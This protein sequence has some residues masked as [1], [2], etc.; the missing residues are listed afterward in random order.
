MAGFVKG[1]EGTLVLETKELLLAVLELS[2]PLVLS[3]GARGDELAQRAD[4]LERDSRHR[5]VS[6]DDSQLAARIDSRRVPAEREVGLS[7]LL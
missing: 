6:C 4:L 7:S 5:Q 3:G 1:A 2:H